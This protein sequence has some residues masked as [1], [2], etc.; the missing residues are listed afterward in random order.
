MEDSVIQG[1]K[2]DF[3]METVN[4]NLYPAAVGKAGRVCLA[5][6]DIVLT[7]G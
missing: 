6:R 7:C 2:D 3:D 4:G 1:T 5:D